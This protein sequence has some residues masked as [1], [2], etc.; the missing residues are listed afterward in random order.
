M[1]TSSSS[2]SSAAMTSVPADQAAGFK[3]CC[4]NTG[5]YD[6]SRR[7]YFFQAEA[8]RLHPEPTSQPNR[9]VDRGPIA[10]SH[11]RVSLKIR[12]LLCIQFACTF[13]RNSCIRGHPSGE[14]IASL[15]FKS[16][17]HSLQT[18]PGRISG[19]T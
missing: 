10:R 18:T 19:T 3:R 2:R 4:M 17:S 15:N 13:F 11:A 7:N 16:P 1:E 14:L 9:P 12:D 5:R 6:G 8:G